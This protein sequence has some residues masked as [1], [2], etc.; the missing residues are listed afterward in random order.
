MHSAVLSLVAPAPWGPDKSSGQGVSRQP[1]PVTRNIV[2][3]QN[4]R[5]AVE[6]LLAEIIKSDK[7]KTRE[8]L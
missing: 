5:L 6:S 8:T 1:Q 4:A 2:R 3:Q 7:S